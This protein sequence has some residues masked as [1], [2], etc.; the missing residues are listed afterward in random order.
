MAVR[1]IAVKR[2]I[3][4]IGEKYTWQGWTE[5]LLYIDTMDVVDDVANKD[6]SEM[7]TVEIAAKHEVWVR[8]KLDR[9]EDTKNVPE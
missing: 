3:T 2:P 7:F 4:V 8:A 1:C 9:K 6:I 5:D